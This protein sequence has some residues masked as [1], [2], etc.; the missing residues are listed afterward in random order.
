MKFQVSVAALCLLVGQTWAACRQVSN[1]E[2]DALRVVE[3][4]PWDR[5]T[6]TTF[7]CPTSQAAVDSTFRL[8]IFVFTSVPQDLTFKITGMWETSE[9]SSS[10]F[11]CS[12]GSSEERLLPGYGQVLRKVEVV[13]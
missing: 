10:Y 7:R 13:A 6:Q 12:A 3:D 2:G 9:T 1:E 11:F 8:N 5:S 4:C